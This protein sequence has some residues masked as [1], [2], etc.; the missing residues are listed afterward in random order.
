MATNNKT[1]NTRIKMKRD[2]SANWTSNNPVLLDGEIIIVDTAEGSVRFKIGDGT[3]TYSQLP[4]EDEAIR[5]LISSEVETLEDSI[6]DLDSDIQAILQDLAT[7]PTTD[8]NTAH[9]HSAGNGITLSGS[10]GISG[11]TTISAKAGTGITVTSAG[12]NNAGVRSITQDSTDGHKLTIN[13]N[14]TSSTITIPDNDTTYGVATASKD[15]LMSASDKNYLDSL[16]SAM[17]TEKLQVSGVAQNGRVYSNVLTA[18]STET[19]DEIIIKTKI[20]FFSG[21][22]MP[23]IHLKGYAYGVQSPIEL[24]V[25][26]YIYSDAFSSAGATST[27]PWDPIIYLSTYTEDSQKYVALSLNKSIYFPRFVV[28]YTDIWASESTSRNAYAEGWTVEFNTT[29]N[30][31]AS[32]IPEDDKVTVSYKDIANNAA[33]A[34]KF[35]TAQT[36]ELK[37]DVTGSA[38]SQAGWSVATTLANS[39]VTANSYGPSANVS[40]YGKTFTVPYITVDAKGRITSA[41]NKTMTMPSAQDLSGYALKTD[42]TSGTITVEKATT[43]SSLDATGIA[44][45]E[46]IK[47]SNAAAADTATTATT[48]NKVANSLTIGSKTYNGSA[49]VSITASDLGLSNAL[50]FVGTTTTALTDGATTSPIVINSANHTPTTGNVVIVSGTDQEFVWTGSAWEELGNAGSHSKIGHTHSVTH[51]PA[52][53]VSK[54]TFTGTQGDVSVS[55][56]PAGTVSKPT[57]SGTKA[58]ISSSYT[59]AGTVSAP[60]FTGDEATITVSFTP[61]GTVSKPSFTGSAVNSGAPDTTNV[62]TIYQITGVGSLPS[63]D[64]STGTLPSASLS[65]GTLPSASISDG[66]VSLTGSVTDR[67]LTIGVSY[68][69]QVL[70]F[71]AGTLPSLTWSAGTLPSAT[72]SAGSLPTRSSV[73]MPNTKHTH[74]VTAAGSVSQ[75]TFT[76]TADSAS[77]TY[78][79]TGTISAPTFTGTAGTA[80]A[81][82]TP[83]GSVSQPTFT[84]TAGTGTGKFTPAGTV[85]QPTFTGTEATIT[86]TGAT[87]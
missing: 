75:P 49:A 32:I 30:S 2:T 67:H 87:N 69:K 7:R 45:V 71:S 4:F 79:P 31:G 19:P 46:D 66:A 60:T 9:A 3:K 38:S 58:T 44:Q 76:G 62:S 37:G 48:A 82:Y 17:V 54:P 27:C 5:N 78:T 41:S 21:H 56:T 72:F 50:K 63:L 6:A 84:G 61:E 43:A 10:G 16:S 22:V 40:G 11:T 25:A 47:V 26:F 24:T 68:T 35:K 36:I 59:P 18:K 80:T 85:S 42:L 39:G 65:K 81:T 74:S 14:G 70:T 51:K 29:S 64:F 1:L 33:T 53:T 83:A 34:S 73:S 28:D 52:G 57:F 55:Y 23:L 12:I 15:G 20:P 8:T 86:T 13:T 77:S